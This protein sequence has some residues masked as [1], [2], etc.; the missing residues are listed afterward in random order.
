MYSCVMSP[1]PHT[2]ALSNRNKNEVL[3]SS[4]VSHIESEQNLGNVE[5][6]SYKLMWGKNSYQE[7]SFA[8][9][10]AYFVGFFMND[11]WLNSIK[12]DLVFGFGSAH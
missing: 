1:S 12:M 7:L 4:F 5:Q 3:A 9:Y 6:G 11:I 2:V 10:R 8:M